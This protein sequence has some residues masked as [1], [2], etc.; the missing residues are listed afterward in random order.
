[1][2]IGGSAIVVTSGAFPSTPTTNINGK[3]QL[4]TIPATH[5]LVLTGVTSGTSGQV[6]S[7]TDSNGN[8][9]SQNIS[10]PYSGDITFT[11][12]YVD[13]ITQVLVGCS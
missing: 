10:N 1:M 13:A 3:T 7:C 5:T 4:I 2:T 11:G 9:Q 12:V 6:I 8:V